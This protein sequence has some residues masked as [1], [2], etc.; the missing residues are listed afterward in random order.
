MSIHRV[1]PTTAHNLAAWQDF[2]LQHDS[3]TIVLLSQ[4]LP[5][6]ATGLQFVRR[7]TFAGQTD[8][9]TGPWKAAMGAPQLGASSWNSTMKIGFNN[10]NFPVLSLSNASTL[11]ADDTEALLT[12]KSPVLSHGSRVRGCH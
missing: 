11:P 4:A 10:R 7:G 1:R 12:G 2:E 8:V 6:S 5:S 3:S 9:W